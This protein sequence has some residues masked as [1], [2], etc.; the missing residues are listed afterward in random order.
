M[1]C[2]SY[3]INAKDATSVGRG[4]RHP[5]AET[6]AEPGPRRV[7]LC[8]STLSLLLSPLSPLPA[9]DWKRLTC[10]ARQGFPRA[11][12]KEMLEVCENDVETATSLLLEGG[13]L[14][15]HE[16][17]PGLQLD[18]PRVPT[19][20]LNEGSVDPGLPLAIA[21]RVDGLSDTDVAPLAGPDVA[22]HS[23]PPEVGGT[24]TVSHRSPAV[25]GMDTV[26]PA[27]G[28]SQA[29]A[30]EVP[31]SADPV[32]VFKACMLAE[33]QQLTYLAEQGEWRELVQSASR[34]LTETFQPEY[35]ALKAA[36]GKELA[37]SHAISFKRML[38]DLRARAHEQT[39]MFEHA[40]HDI[41]STLKLGH[42]GDL[43]V[44]LYVRRAECLLGL[45]QPEKVRHPPASIARP[46]SPSPVRLFWSARVAG[47]GRVSLSRGH[48]TRAR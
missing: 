7:G 42:G 2:C 12:S 8:H 43:D 9:R 41:D 6:A 15:S 14:N 18:L 45:K 33:Q 25:P 40:I 23:E 48:T 30:A 36:M 39:D 22:S 26:T 44:A 1:D 27:A 5:G 29:P 31:P 34:A 32:A 17:P 38:L 35:D 3:L 16:E 10:A 28:P 21:T 13:V 47:L 11:T 19:A 4:G 24:W 20:G 37:H 46:P